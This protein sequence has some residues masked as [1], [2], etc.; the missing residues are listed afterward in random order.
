MTHK[1]CHLN[2]RENKF[3]QNNLIATI[4][5]SHH[6]NIY[7]N[8]IH[9]KQRICEIWNHNDNN[10]NNKYSSMSATSP[11]CNTHA[12]CSCVCLTSFMGSVCGEYLFMKGIITVREA[13][14]GI[15]IM[16]FISSKSGW[17]WAWGGHEWDVCLGVEPETAFHN[18][19]WRSCWICV[20]VS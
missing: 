8:K 13:S 16:S 19:K 4:N 6:Q 15:K 7:E 11:K 18:K 2:D 12:S 17:L 10:N 20:F 9:G 5:I 14:W 3:F 1:T